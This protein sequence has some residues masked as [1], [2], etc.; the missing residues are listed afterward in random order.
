[1]KTEAPEICEDPLGVDRAAVHLGVE[2]QIARLLRD[3][4]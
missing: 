3:N 2:T 4:L 1:L